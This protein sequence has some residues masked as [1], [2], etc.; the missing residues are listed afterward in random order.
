MSVFPQ[1][2]IK[3]PAKGFTLIEA[4]IALVI[5]ATGLLA[6]AKMQGDVLE[7]SGQ[8]KARSEALKY[9]QQ[10]IEELR[11]FADETAYA[12]MDNGADAP[13]GT[14]AVFSRSWT[15][16]PAA[17]LNYKTMTVD[18]AWTDKD[19]NQSVQLNSFI[20]KTNPAKSGGLLITDG[21]GGGG[22]G[23]A[24]NGDTEGGG[25][26]DGGADGNSDGDGNNDGG[27]DND[28]S[29]GGDNNNG[30]SGDDGGNSCTSQEIAGTITKSGQ[31]QAH[32]VQ[33]TP[34]LGNCTVSGNANSA[35]YSCVVPCNGSL[36]IGISTSQGGGW[37]SPTT[38]TFDL[39]SLADTT[40]AG[41]ITASK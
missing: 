41:T 28:G 5:L 7:G 6:L 31:G 17:S 25:D 13:A 14:N 19:G 37:V 27:G 4:L 18:V 8:T 38:M 9:A 1:K 36:L 39:S 30:G 16:T 29:D 10:K 3:A 21:A 35:S 34:S 11:A 22:T 32:K 40:T 12:N 20:A 24:G 26:S 15:V 2:N 33:L 23:S